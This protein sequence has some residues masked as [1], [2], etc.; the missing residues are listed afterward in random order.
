MT[1]A[2]R[3]FEV[4]ACQRLRTFPVAVD[5]ALPWKAVASFRPALR[6]DGLWRLAGC[7]TARRETAALVCGQDGTARAVRSQR[8]ELMADVACSGFVSSTMAAFFWVS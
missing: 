8:H 3:L 6:G 7:R 4:A 1:A 2:A 5:A